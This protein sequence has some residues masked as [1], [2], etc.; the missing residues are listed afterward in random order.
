ML[1]KWGITFKEIRIDDDSD[2][3]KDFIEVTHGARTVPQIIIDG[4]P[5]GGFTELTKLHLNG[6]LDELM[7]SENG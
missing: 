7:R 5:I 6:G 2:A 3:M 4:K 1:D